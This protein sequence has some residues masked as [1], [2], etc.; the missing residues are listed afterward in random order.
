MAFT[1]LGCF[2]SWRRDAVSELLFSAAL[3][4][5]RVYDPI[6]LG[7]HEADFMTYR[8]A[9]GSSPRIEHANLN[10]AFGTNNG[11][12]TLFAYLRRHLVCS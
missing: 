9:H 8:N 2:T 10:P 1:A 12:W 6:L 5:D 7:V 4:D 11:L 3:P